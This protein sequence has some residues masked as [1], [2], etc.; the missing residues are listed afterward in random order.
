[1][2]PS[3]VVWSIIV[4]ILILFI[5]IIC[6]S[7]YTVKQ[8]TYRVIER[9]GKFKKILPFLSGTFFCAALVYGCTG[10]FLLLFHR[11]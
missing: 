11:Q 1:M 7:F 2:N 4:I 5:I 3:I 8:N 6:G 9:L 10:H